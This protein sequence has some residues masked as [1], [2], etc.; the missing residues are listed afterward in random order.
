MNNNDPE[1]QTGAPVD[2]STSKVISDTFFVS[3]SKIG[4]TLL[5][6]VRS[7]ILGRLL[8]PTLY[9]VLNIPV[10]YIQLLVLLSNIGFTTAVIKLVPEYLQKGRRDLAAM[11]YRSAVLL[12]VVLSVLWC[13]L[14]IAF[15]PWIA[16]NVAHESD[17][18]LPIRIYALIIPFLALNAFYAVAF[19][20]VQRGKLRAI[21]TALHGV[22]N[23]ALPI[24][25]VLWRGDII[26][27]IVGF[28]TAEVIGALIFTILFH[29]KAISRWTETPGPL[30][31]GMGEVF[32]FG[33]LFFFANLGWNMINTVDRIMVK[34]YLPSD[35]LGF[36]AMAAI[37]IT[38][39]S[40]VSST[41]GTALIPSL[42]AARVTGGMD[43]FRRQIRSTGRITL[44]ALV[45][46]VLAIWC[47]SEDVF[48]IV[49]PKFLPS[50]EIVRI[51]VFVGLID[52]FCRI[53][54]A[55]LASHA[56][57]G[58]SASAYVFAALLNVALNA[59]LI[60]RMGITGAAVATLTTFL[61]L[62]VILQVMMYSISRTRI[63]P[64]SL[65]H[66]LVLSLIY[67]LL[68]FAT[69]SL[70]S[71][72]RIVIVLA[73]GSVIYNILAAVTGLIRISDL[74]TAE[75][76]LR[77]REHVAHVRIALFGI[78]IIK[79]ITRR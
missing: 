73:A 64:M 62:A 41:A 61:V 46:I 25:A 77:P 19:L 49:L 1:D 2:L 13:F 5:K 39:L 59:I 11:I 36:Y 51:L 70:S 50:A 20:A 32:S 15:A 43:T 42:T 75:A 4:V 14:L 9:G 10:S 34:F 40:A 68:S 29:R 22:L 18:T 6:P 67:P 63:S 35:Q 28:L 44:I 69:G 72:A 53:S 26:S 78:G 74:E 7:V 45:P 79:N 47:L 3:A 60:P 30:S 52:I 66:P 57:G 76:T 16:E 65:L 33:F 37:V 71:W 24:A 12:T 21:I 56:K 58:L 31:R 27:V 55:A 17:A 54:W 8:G 38:A 23:V 48:S